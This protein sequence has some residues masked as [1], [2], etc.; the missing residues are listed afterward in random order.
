LF[1]ERRLLLR[2]AVAPLS[3]CSSI[4]LLLLLLPKLLLLGFGEHVGA[5]FGATFTTFVALIIIIITAIV[6]C[7]CL[8]L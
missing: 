2:L 6:V 8:L 7:R 5:T 1:A 3:L 4:G